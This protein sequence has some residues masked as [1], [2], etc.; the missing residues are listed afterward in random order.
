MPKVNRRS[1]LR[2][3]DVGAA[4]SNIGEPL[5]DPEP[6]DEDEDRCLG[7]ELARMSSRLTLRSELMVATDVSSNS[8][9]F[10]AV[11]VNVNDQMRLMSEGNCRVGI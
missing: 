3:G 1:L 10:E 2:R 6:L 11:M 8:V 9:N 4:E 5:D 7:S